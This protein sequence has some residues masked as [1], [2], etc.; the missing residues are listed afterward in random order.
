MLVRGSEVLPVAIFISVWNGTPDPLATTSRPTLSL[1]RGNLR[2]TYSKS[3]IGPILTTAGYPCQPRVVIFQNQNRLVIDKRKFTPRQILRDNV[4]ALLKS[5]IGPDSQLSLGAKA[6][7]GGQATIGRIVREE[8][9]NT[10]LET[11]AA[12]A[13]A[14]GLE[15]WQLLVAGMDPK[16]PPVLTPVSKEEKEL[17]A[18]LRQL[19]Q[20]V[21]KTIP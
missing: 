19:Y 16:N 12:I 20:D 10:K 3:D 14:Y 7:T 8:G 15:A 5:G 6:G 4:T 9:E 1:P 2:R 17:W 18:R 21:G 11:I 13:K